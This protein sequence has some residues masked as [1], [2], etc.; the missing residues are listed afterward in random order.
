M[1]I[2]LYQKFYVKCLFIDNKCNNYTEVITNFKEKFKN[3]KFILT[4]EIVKKIKAN[5]IGGIK[6]ATIKDITQSLTLLNKDLIID[7]FHVKSEYL[8]KNKKIEER[9]QDIILIADKKMITSLDTSKGKQFGIDCTFK[10]IPKIFKPYK[11]MTIYS[12][13]ENENKVI[14]SAILCIK[15]TDTEYLKKI[16]AYLNINYKFAPI[17]ITCD[18]DKAQIKALKECYFF[19]KKPY[20]I[21]C[22]FDFT[23]CIIKKFKEYHIIQKKLNK[24]SYELLRK[25]EIL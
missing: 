4:E 17:S 12:I 3:I 13:N 21:C 24:H 2:K 16:F 23:Q 9:D 8:N 5:T 6:N 1:D 25:V 22:F 11:L 10:V 7:N 15:Y 20:I 14:I 19:Q 18:F